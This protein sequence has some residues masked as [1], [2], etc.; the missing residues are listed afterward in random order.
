MRPS[1]AVRLTNGLAVSTARYHP[2]AVGVDPPG[3]QPVVDAPELVGSLLPQAGPHAVEPTM[4]VKTMVTVP[5]PSSTR[6]HR[7]RTGV[8]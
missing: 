8:A 3:Q 5:G 2:V 1:S 6:R 4:S 7:H